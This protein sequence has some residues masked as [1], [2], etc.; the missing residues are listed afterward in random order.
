MN[1]ALISMTSKE[2]TRPQIRQKVK[3]KR[4]K[5]YQA[6]E[7]LNLSLVQVKRLCKQYKKEGAKGLVSK[8]RGSRGNHRLPDN[9]NKKPLI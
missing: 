4:L 9:L 7:Y 1:K 8:K 3:E 6:A 5:Q 2:L